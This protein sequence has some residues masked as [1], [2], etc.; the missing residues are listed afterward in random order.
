MATF[1]LFV[2]IWSLAWGMKHSLYNIFVLINGTI[3]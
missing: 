1:L 3:G 2:W